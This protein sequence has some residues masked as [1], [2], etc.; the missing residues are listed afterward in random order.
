MDK[1]AEEYLSHY[2]EF[3][4]KFAN[5][6]KRTGLTSEEHQNLNMEMQQWGQSWQPIYNSLSESEKSTFL[7][8]YQRITREMTG[9]F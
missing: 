7:L 5:E 1:K 3:M 9:K 2:N 6:L 8:E 4:V